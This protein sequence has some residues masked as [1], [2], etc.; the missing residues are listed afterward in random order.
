MSGPDLGVPPILLPVTVV[1]ALALIAHFGR[2]HC[3][4]DAVRGAVLQLRPHHRR[5]DG[6]SGGG[7]AYC[8]RD[9]EVLG[10][11]A[12]TLLQRLPKQE[13]PPPSPVALTLFFFFTVGMDAEPTERT[14]LTANAA[15]RRV[16][17]AAAAG[18]ASS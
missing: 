12:K 14:R 1:A 18:F 11:G 7:L 15:P 5:R 6:G 8:A 13:S 16:T 3:V 10:L 9:R 17:I 4:L 2:R